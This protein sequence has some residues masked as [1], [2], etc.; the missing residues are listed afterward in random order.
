MLVSRVEPDQVLDE[1]EAGLQEELRQAKARQHM[2][3]EGI[4]GV[5]AG[6]DPGEVEARVKKAGQDVA[7]PA[8]TPPT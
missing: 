3:I 2:V 5:Q 4:V 7:L 1:L 6:I 8:A